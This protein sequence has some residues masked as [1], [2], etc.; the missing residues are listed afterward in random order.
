MLQVEQFEVSHEITMI[1]S[2]QV[3]GITVQQLAILSKHSMEVVAIPGLCIP[4]IEM[5]ILHDRVLMVD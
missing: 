3:F 2:L 5:D 4:R 1:I